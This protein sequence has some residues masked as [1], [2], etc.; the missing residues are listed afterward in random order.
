MLGASGHICDLFK[1]SVPQDFAILVS[2]SDG[3][4]LAE[5]SRR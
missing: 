3:S 2:I 5:L 1:I 4:H